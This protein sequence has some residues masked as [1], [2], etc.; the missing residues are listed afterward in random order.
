MKNLKELG[1]INWSRYVDDVVSVIT[2]IVR[3]NILIMHIH[4]NQPLN[5]FYFLIFIISVI[6][7]FCIFRDSL[8][9]ETRISEN[10]Q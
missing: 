10:L 1:V 2:N 8:K 6:I 9:M 5:L 7:I 3:I 4:A